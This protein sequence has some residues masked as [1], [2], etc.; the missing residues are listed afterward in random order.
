MHWTIYRSTAPIGIC[1]VG[2][3]NVCSPSMKYM[4]CTIYMCTRT[5]KVATPLGNT[6]YACEQQS[7]CLE[8]L[9]F[10]LLYL[11]TI[12]ITCYMRYRLLRQCYRPFG[13]TFQR[14]R[15]KT[16]YSMHILHL[17]PILPKIHLI[18]QNGQND[19]V[20]QGGQS[21]QIGG[22]RIVSW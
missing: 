5:T 3:Q 2:L 20:G 10:F 6:Q 22:E 17:S 16:K 19:Q 8:I 7:S 11:G 14:K 9:K 15:N 1:F 4:H 21:G 12:W 13:L 18:I